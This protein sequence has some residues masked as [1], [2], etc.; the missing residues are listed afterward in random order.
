MA[1][2]V[3]TALNYSVTMRGPTATSRLSGIATGW[4]IES[5]AGPVKIFE[6]VAIY[7]VL[8]SRVIP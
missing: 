7:Y 3:T 5:A 2:G 6:F 8:R 1:T 4:A